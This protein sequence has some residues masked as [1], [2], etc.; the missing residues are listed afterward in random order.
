[1]VKLV[2]CVRRR[3]GSTIAEF[4]AAW[5]DYGRE[6]RRMALEMGAIGA[7][8]STTLESPVN[9]AL[10]RQRGSAEPFDGIAEVVWT[11]GSEALA[12]AEEPATVERI[13][14]FRK[15]QEGFADVSASAF[16]FVHEIDVYEEL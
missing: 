3:P 13:A 12:S 15:L 4:R 14:A 5:E 10:R 11:R 6:L 9:E 16:F 2:Q 1:M 8:L 7:R